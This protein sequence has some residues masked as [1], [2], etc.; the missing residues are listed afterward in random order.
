MNER[1]ETT[2]K[3]PLGTMLRE[4]YEGDAEAF[5]TVWSD[6]M[7]MEAMRGEYMLRSLAE[8]DELEKYALDN[9]R[10]T[11]LDV[12]AGSG[13]HSLVLQERDLDVEA[14][15]ISP[16]CVELMR[17]QGVRKVHHCNVFSPGMPRFDTVLMLMNGIGLCGSIDGLHDFL[18]RLDGLL[19]PG[20]QLIVDSTDLTGQFL[21][22]GEQVFDDAGYCGETEF[23]MIYKG[24]RSDPFSW[25]YIDFPLL[26]SICAEHGYL[27]ELLMSFVNDRYLAR[28]TAQPCEKNGGRLEA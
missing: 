5:L 4:Y 11:V 19:K 21:E 12:G 2:A 13:C 18:E 7:E 10:G 3:D 6:S 20:G 25:L 8:M 22:I 16:G 1:I 24:L 28:I 26:E 14:V 23:V 17:T 9:C 27:C 15:D